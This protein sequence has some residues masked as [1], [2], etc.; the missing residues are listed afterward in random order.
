M[1]KNTLSRRKLL[2]TSGAAVSLNIVK[3]GK[4][5]EPKLLGRLAGEEILKKSINNFSKKR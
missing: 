1:A 3:S 2:A 4:I 5:S